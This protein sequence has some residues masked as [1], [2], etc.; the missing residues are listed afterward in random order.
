MLRR[1]LTA[2]T[3]VATLLGP[4][5]QTTAQDNTGALKDLATA[6]DSRQRVA[7]A[8]VL[9]KATNPGARPALEKALQDKDP[10]VRAAAAAA[11]GTRGEQASLPALRA[12]LSKEEVVNVRTQLD[13]TVQRLASKAPVRFLVSLGKVENRSG[14]KDAGVND[15][16][17]G[18]T[19]AKAALIP[20]V[21]V[22]S[23]GV[24]P[25][26][27]GQSR[28]LPSITLDAAITHLANGQQGGDVS[29]AAKVEFLLR[30][31]PEQALKGSLSG[32]ARA[33]AEARSVR[34]PAQIAQL[35]RDAVSGAVES[36]FRGATSALE[37]AAGLSK[38]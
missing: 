18:E 8:L 28:K 23:E 13:A 31:Q 12:A 25:V 5:A 29:Y 1:L 17:R 15:I 27:A 35:Q 14:V 24:D 6:T 4:I 10:S 20:G 2:V 38:R 36:A 22:L 11:L 32:S 37:S 7:A 33:L 16:L 34:G 3:L 26:A 30:K 21:E 19:R 9:G